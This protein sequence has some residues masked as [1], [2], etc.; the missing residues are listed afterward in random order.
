VPKEQLLCHHK[1]LCSHRGADTIIDG[2][3]KSIDADKLKVVLTALQGKDHTLKLDNKVTVNRGG[4]ESSGGL[5]EGDMVCLC[6]DS[7]VVNDTIRYVVVQE[8]DTKN[9]HLMRVTIK[10]YDAA[11]KQLS[12]TDVAEKKTRPSP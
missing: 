2:K 7:G 5:K 1:G 10:G 11:K 4:K 6:Y 12:V 9:C 3:I 8:G